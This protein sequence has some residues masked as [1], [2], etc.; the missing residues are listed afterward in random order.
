MEDPTHK[1]TTIIST[2]VPTE[3]GEAID[4]EVAR[5]GTNR[6]HIAR[7]ILYGHIKLPAELI[8]QRGGASE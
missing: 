2:Q 4:K 8:P 3:V 1:K 6:S 5:T 7:E